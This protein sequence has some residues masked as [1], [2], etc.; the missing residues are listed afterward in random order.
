MPT[1]G[2]P[3]AAPDAPFSTLQVE[4]TSTV[5][6]AAEE[7]RRAIF[8]GEIESGT[9]LRE[10]ALADSLGVSRPTIRE[11]LGMLVAEG[12][13][14][15]E[16]HRGVH[17]ATPERESV[18]DVCAAR[19]VL[20]GAGVSRWR[21]A[22]DEQ[23]DHVRASLRAYTDAI[24]AEGSYQELNTLHL[25]FHVSLVGLAGS[26]RLVS[27]ADTL[28]IELKLALAQVERIARNAHDQADTHV[29]LVQL[30]EDDDIDA[31]ITFLKG[32]L[33][34]AETEIVEALGL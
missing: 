16:P 34:D 12:L 11:A 22:T 4:H 9:A 23:R 32:H 15:R 33:E 6:R 1:P 18:H 21:D 8:E 17:V 14:A 20:E 19:F 24:E 25:A 28:M 3:L 13:A 26:P 5:E 31:A 27:M 10:V 29:A 7:L 2:T 30:L